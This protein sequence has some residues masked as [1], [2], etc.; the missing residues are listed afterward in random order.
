[1]TPHLTPPKTLQG[2]DH[3]Y[4]D[5]PR[6][7]ERRR[8]RGGVEKMHGGDLDLEDKRLDDLKKELDEH[9]GKPK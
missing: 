9:R 7:P 6:N 2:P 8:V 1:M 5:D 4:K 3:H